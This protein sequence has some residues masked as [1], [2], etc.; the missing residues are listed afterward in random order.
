MADSLDPILDR[1]EISNDANDYVESSTLDNII[2]E[3][4]NG[5]DTGISMKNLAFSWRTIA[6]PTDI[7]I[8]IE[9]TKKFKVE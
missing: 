6:A 7:T 4:F 8:S 3:C 5:K 2:V 1:I 9:K